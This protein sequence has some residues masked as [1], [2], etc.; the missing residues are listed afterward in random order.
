MV[1]CDYMPSEDPAFEVSYSLL[2][3]FLNLDIGDIIQDRGRYQLPTMFEDT[4][5]VSF[6]PC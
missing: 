2:H 1:S 4:P 3:A 5:W 6:L